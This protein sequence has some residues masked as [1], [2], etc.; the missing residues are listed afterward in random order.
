MG[1]V[2]ASIKLSRMSS[3]PLPSER[4]FTLQ[5]SNFRKIWTGGYM[6]ITTREPTPESTV[7]E[8]LRCRHSRIASAWPKR[9]C[10]ISN[11]R[12][13]TRKTVY[14]LPATKKRPVRPLQGRMIYHPFIL[15]LQISKRMITAAEAVNGQ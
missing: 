5:L 4:K 3:T 8:K 1:F 15:A 6:C 10:R 11:T 14:P 12:K 9:K 7:M 2:N 13:R